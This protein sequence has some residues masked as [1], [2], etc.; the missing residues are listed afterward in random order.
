MILSPDA[1]VYL[2]L[3]DVAVCFNNIVDENT[4]Y[5]YSRLTDENIMVQEHV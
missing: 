1:T 2:V 5:I 3:G 4:E